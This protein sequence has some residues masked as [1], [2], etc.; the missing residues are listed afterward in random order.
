I[1]R[2]YRQISS[3]NKS[4]LEDQSFLNM[5][6][7]RQKDTYGCV[8]ADSSKIRHLSDEDFT[9]ELKAALDAWKTSRVRGIWFHCDRLDSRFIP[10]LV[11]Q[12]FE[13]HHAQPQYCSLTRWLPEDVSS[14][15]PKYPHMHIGCGGIVVDAEGRFL[16]MREKKGHYLG[17]KFPGGLADP[18]ENIY[19]SASR[20]VREETGIDAEGVAVLSFRQVNAAQWK[21]TGDI[22]FLI[23][24]RPKDES[25]KEVTPCTVEAADAKWMTRS[26]MDDLPN[27]LFHSTLRKTLATYDKWLESGSKGLVVEQSDSPIRRHVQMYT[28]AVDFTPRI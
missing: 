11:E 23:V 13:F 21:N 10:I 16:L 3:L 1:R 7:P 14:T 4:Q 5:A 26:E 17:W 27:E 15:L 20:E 18:N 28:F 9:S 24:M 12:G 2:V 25:K 8:S 19:E 22:Y 6:L